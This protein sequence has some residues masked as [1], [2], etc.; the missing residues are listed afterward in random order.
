MTEDAPRD[1]PKHIKKTSALTTTGGTARESRPNLDRLN[2]YLT[3]S[4]KTFEDQHSHFFLQDPPPHS[5]NPIH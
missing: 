4:D 1:K 3:V 2:D 5:K